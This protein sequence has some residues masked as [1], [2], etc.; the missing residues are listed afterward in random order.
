M[1]DE[2]FMRIALGEAERAR[3]IGEVPVGAVLVC[4]GQLLSSAHNLVEQLCDPTAHAE[5][6]VIREAAR[7]LN[8]WRLTGCTVYVTKEPCLMCLS[9]LCVARVSR[10][11]YGASDERFPS[12]DAF[13]STGA[14]PSGRILITGGVLASECRELLRV[15]FDDIR[16]GAG[17]VERGGL[18]NR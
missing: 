2:Y 16:R 10:I 12:V 6:L 15:F 14:F 7:K 9:A 8:N 17:V 5:I 1:R 4:D 3:V 18:E 13:L 11:V